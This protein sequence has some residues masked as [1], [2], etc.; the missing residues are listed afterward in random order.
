MEKEN[1]R[2]KIISFPR[3]IIFNN[4][5]NLHKPLARKKIVTSFRRLR[6]ISRELRTQNSRGGE[7]WDENNFS[8]LEFWYPRMWRA[9]LFSGKVGGC[10]LIASK[11]PISCVFSPKL[12]ASLHECA[13]HLR[14]FIQRPAIGR[15]GR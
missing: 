11:R 2:S 12:S 1:T 5:S 10:R 6:L 14:D 13:R 4:I 7:K 9:D 3:L 15:N 8:N